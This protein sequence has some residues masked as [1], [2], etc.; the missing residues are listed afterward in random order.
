MISAYSKLI[1]R[2]IHR[3][4]LFFVL[5]EPALNEKVDIERFNSFSNKLSSG[6]TSTIGVHCCGKLELDLYEAIS[7][8]FKQLDW[9]L[10]K[11]EQIPK[12]GRF[13]GGFEKFDHEIC[14][15]LSFQSGNIIISP[16]CGLY[17]H[18]NPE[19]IF[20]QLQTVKNILIKK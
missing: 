5:D 6:T 16:S 10:Y 2:L 11:L 14:Q 13:F 20:E 8:E 12:N 9:A 18:S 4:D 7:L 3:G 15:K 1:G 17:G 19:E